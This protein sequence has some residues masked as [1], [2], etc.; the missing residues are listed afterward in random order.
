MTANRL[1]LAATPLL[2]LLSACGGGENEEPPRPPAPAAVVAGEVEEFNCFSFDFTNGTELDVVDLHFTMPT[3]VEAKFPGGPDGWGANQEPGELEFRTPPPPPPHE[4]G[5]TQPP[6]PEPNPIGPGQEME[7]FVFYLPEG[8]FPDNTVDFSHPDG[9]RTEDVEIRQ[10]GDA[11][12]TVSPSDTLYCTEITV[13]PPPGSDVR[14]IELTRSGGISPAFEEVELPDNLA[15]NEGASNADS[16][17]IL[18]RGTSPLG[19][20]VTFQIYT[21]K[22]RVTIDWTLKDG[23]NQPIPGANGEVQLGE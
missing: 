20:P 19:G 6:P 10:G 2:L 3:G 8:R 1:I 21:K 22:R 15:N 17:S 5:T 23:Q 14:V 7:G 16:L 11:T 13:T 12:D 18:V 9:T 4:P